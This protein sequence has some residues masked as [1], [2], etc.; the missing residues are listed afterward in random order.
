MNKRIVALLL[1]IGIVSSSTVTVF[2]DP[3]ESQLNSQLQEQ[4][5]NINDSKKSLQELQSKREDIESNIELIDTDI[6]QMMRDISDT[7]KKIESTQLDIKAAQGEIKKAEDNMK[8]EKD[9][10]DQRMRSMYINGFDGYLSIIL[11]SKGFS[12]FLSRVDD[13]KRI[14]DADKVTVAKLE[15][16]K[17]EVQKKKDA[18][19]K[20]N[21]KLVA[22][23]AD[24]ES[25]LAKL[26]EDKDKQAKLIDSLKEQEKQYASEIAAE[27]KK[28]A[29][30]MALIKKI[31]ESATNLSPSRGQTPYSTNGVVAFATNYLGVPY[32]WGGTSPNPGFDCSGF[33]Q[34]VYRHFGISLPRVASSQATVG[35][36]VDKSNLQP[37]DLVFF[38]KPG[39]EIHHVGIYVGNDS[40]IHAPQTRDVVKI[41]VLSSRSDFYIAKRVR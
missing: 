12:D 7:N 25:K 30:T 6:E 32:V 16:K 24:N 33:V 17:G 29:D 8:A 35:T 41:S 19:D 23:K 1:A 28:I 10:F 15:A 18:L 40:Y 21:E 26:K 3:S 2:A 9:L 20:Q 4:Q 39:R 14:I 31:R 38:K 34:Y 5:S 13:V 37:G 36:T 22:L 11:E 27:Q